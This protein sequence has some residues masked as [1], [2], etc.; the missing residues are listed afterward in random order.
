MRGAVVPAVQVAGVGV[1][2][3]TRE[4]AQFLII[5]Y[6]FQNWIM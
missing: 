2:P 3:E 4:T 5:C 6:G 1:P